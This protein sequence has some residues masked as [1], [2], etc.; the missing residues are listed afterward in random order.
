MR[1]SQKPSS[2][3][4]SLRHA[5]VH[6][7]GQGARVRAGVLAGAREGDHDHDDHDHDERTPGLRSVQDSPG[8]N[9]LYISTYVLWIAVI[10]II[11]LTSI[12]TAIIYIF[13]VIGLDTSTFNSNSFVKEI[14]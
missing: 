5:G 14:L 1:L 11:T 9:M 13:S 10:V 3:P 2:K 12:T 7:A 8:G 6:A 4:L